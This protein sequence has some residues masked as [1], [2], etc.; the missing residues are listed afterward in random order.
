MLMYSDVGAEVSVSTTERL[1]EMVV[2]LVNVSRHDIECSATKSVEE[3]NS[4]IIY[5]QNNGDANHFWSNEKFSS[6]LD[7]DIEN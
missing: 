1:N 2:D 7:E 6:V 4:L 3:T 5:L